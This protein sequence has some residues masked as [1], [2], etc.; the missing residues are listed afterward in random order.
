MELDYE[1]LN[2]RISDIKKH[3]QR[4]RD[5]R[6][7]AYKTLTRLHTFLVKR[8]STF[9]DNENKILI[10][11]VNMGLDGELSRN[12][13]CHFV[14]TLSLNMRILSNS[15]MTEQTGEC[16]VFSNVRAIEKILN[17]NRVG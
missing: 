15:D 3:D 11:L 9:T 8:T 10:Y 1:L 7:K 4:L 12:N 16:V 13:V 2:K 5:L 17:N 14:E 6:T